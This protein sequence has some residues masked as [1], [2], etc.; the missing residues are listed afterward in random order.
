[1]KCY[2]ERL[3]QDEKKLQEMKEKKRMLN[4]NYAKFSVKRKTDA[5]Y[6]QR[7]KEKPRE[8]GSKTAEPKEVLALQE[9]NH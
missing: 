3:Q 6:D 5:N 1:M 2:Y 8:N 7:Q 9:M 4:A